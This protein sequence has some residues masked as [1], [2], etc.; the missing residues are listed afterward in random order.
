ML[1]VGA[2]PTGLVL[3]SELA[4]R[5]VPVEIVERQAAPSGQ[6]RGGGVNARTGE[7]LAM[8]GLYA[9]MRARSLPR[10]GGVG[11]F[12]GL[13]VELDHR[14]WRS[15]HPGMMIPQDRME[16][17]FEQ[18]L[19]GLGVRVRRSTT[20]TGL[21]QDESGVRV[22][23]DGPHGAVELAAR[24]LVACDG[25]HSTVR[26]LTG[27]PFP[28]R[29]G[30][31]SAV[32][33]DV[34]LTAVSETVP[35]KVQHLSAHTRTGCEAW[36]LTHPLGDGVYR[37]VFGSP[38]QRLHDRR[39]PVDDDEI[40]RAL[41]A[42]HGP[43]TVLGHVL[44]ATRFSDA[45]RQVEHYRVGSV[46]FAGDAAHIHPPSGGQGLNLGVQ[47]AMNLGW[48]L[49]AA[50]AGRAPEGLIDSYH[51]ERHPVG[52]RV[53]ET[54]RAQMVIMAPAPDAA[55]ARALREIVLDMARLPDGN[56]YLTGR[57]SGLDLRYDLAADGAEHPLVGSRMPDLDL[58]TDAGPTTVFE[59][60]RS[61]NGLLLE[62]G[63]RSAAGALP[64]GVE[65]V[66][67]RVTGDGV[68]AERVL[69]R[70]DGY[71]A[72]CGAAADDP[73]RALD[74]WFAT[75]VSGPGAYLR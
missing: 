34:A 38:E 61:G 4:M 37:I 22:A 69:V 55:E 63:G 45:T 28:G 39:A 16:A 6:S 66:A 24:W 54:A 18:H 60:L 74:R 50:C 42:V 27:T 19:A 73:A 1:V 68:D 40:A 47:D 51:D 36:M 52:A 71:V 46:L 33:A 58:V 64:V 48:K 67:A 53:I 72:W 75:A 43:E 10:E 35:Q 8:R 31:T 56:R 49:A 29:A 21:V 59:L 57:M 9:A 65:H 32:S 12:A 44:W 15:R 26:S 3:A 7:V 23:A 25:G 62:L 13:P 41:T 14:P 5:G 30:T 2:G 17:V 20:V 11:H 70:P